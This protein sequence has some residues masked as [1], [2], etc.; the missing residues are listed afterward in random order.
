MFPKIVHLINISGNLDLK[1]TSKYANSIQKNAADWEI[2]IWNETNLPKVVL[3][4]HYF[5][6]ALATKKFA[7]ASDVAR[8]YL[9]Y[10]F[11]GIYLDSDVEL[12]RNLKELTKFDF[13]MGFENDYTL[14]TS[15]I[16]TVPGNSILR[17]VCDIYSSQ[18]IRDGS[19]LNIPNVEYFTQA[20]RNNG[21]KLNGQTQR[22][23]DSILLDQSYISPLFF[24]DPQQSLINAKTISVHH[25][26]GS[27]T[28]NQSRKNAVI[29]MG[30]KFFGDYLFLLMRKIR[31]IRR[32]Y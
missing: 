11:G 6:V 29:K 15:L 14:S 4:N 27:W 21:F 17:Y 13:V 28:K 16:A 10:E 19:F 7:Y 24:Y 18:Q 8:A 2:K 26:N 20:V 9:L 25:F 12:K 3:N 5:K 22:I 23:Q 30:H 1:V 32:K 31:Q